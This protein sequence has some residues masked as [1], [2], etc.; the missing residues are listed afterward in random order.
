M[1]IP[2]I[3]LGKE[4]LSRFDDAIK[5]EWLVTNGL[6]GYASSTVLGI[7]TRK[8]HGLLV[9]AFHPPGDRRVCL[10]KV[11]EEIEVGN[12]LYPL[13]SNEFQNEVF[14]QGHSY[15]K[16]FS[17]S[18]F[19]KHVYSVQNI[20]MEKILFMPFETNATLILYNVMNNGDVDAKLRVYPLVN[21]R[22]FHSVTDRWK[23]SQDS[24]K[25]KSRLVLQS[26]GGGYHATGKWIEKLYYREEARRGESSLDDCYQSGYFEFEAKAG[27]NASLALVA[28]ADKDEAT[29]RRTVEGLPGNLH[30]VTALLQRE[31]A[32]RENRL[33]ELYETHKSVTQSE[34]LSLL[35]EAGDAFIVKAAG[36]GYK[37][38][39]SG[40][41]WFEAWGRDAF[42][43]LPG[44]TLV[45]G[46]F[47]DARTLFLSSSKYCSKGLIPNFV[48]DV[49]GQP[50]AYNSVDATLWY[51]NAV[52]QY[53]KYTGDFEFV[54]THL[55]E[56]LKAI[57]EW[58]LKGTLF[59]IHV[60]TDGLLSHGS[61]LT[62]MDAAADGQAV[63]PRIGKA[64]EV[65]ALWY[66]ALKTMELL[67]RKFYE[68]SH[69]EEYASMAAK[70]Q[71][72]FSQRF[73]NGEKRYLYDV[74]TQSDCDDS[75]RPNQVIAVSLDFN[76]LDAEKNENVINCVQQEL[77]TEFGLR[78]LSR[79][80]PR[81]RGVYDGDRRRRDEAYHNGTVW[82][83]L[84]GP[85]TT[86]FLK[87]KG[88]SDSQ[89]EYAMKNFLLPLFIEKTSEVCL[90]TIGEIF[91]GDTPHKTR[92]CVSQAWS[93]AEP[94]RAYVEDVMQV[95]P[96]N[97]EQILKTDE[98]VAQGQ[99][100]HCVKS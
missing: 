97:A 12:T 95:K 69:A 90:G 2:T 47:E 93:I 100:V 81:Y 57:I 51:V 48:P 15:L 86:A 24:S 35:D 71:K 27:K 52:L 98:T 42:V 44:L 67:A 50:P 4:T 49:I 85:F 63:T 84:L 20:E 88:S 70:A 41:H 91:D 65:Q 11:D 94:L 72:S 79:N 83:W 73:W 8:Y 36:S 80:D 17:V 28:A 55:W 92:G 37:A 13:S 31:T 22:H 66:N 82:P 96:K 7:N 53:L 62:W 18:P 25:Q 16:E 21:W 23:A 33:A 32:R 40:Y 39:I 6:G 14:P 30:D 76:M 9:A 3:T 99:N 89:R 26:I 10:A 60:D 1:K 75:L 19:P 54:R 45:S 46:R 58:H 64:V 5:K 78:T 56:T 87:V 38:I 74:V 68:I 34:W 29:A 77:L 43:S 59:D 61:R